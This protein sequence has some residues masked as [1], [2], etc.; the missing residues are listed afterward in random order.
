MELSQTATYRGSLR[1]AFS[2]LLTMVFMEARGEKPLL[3]G[4]CALSGYY[5]GH[6]HPNDID[7]FWKSTAGMESLESRIGRTYQI[8]PDVNEQRGLRRILVQTET[9]D[10]AIHSAILKQRWADPR[11]WQC[12]SVTC[13]DVSLQT[14]DYLGL[15]KLVALGNIRD[16]VEERSLSLYDLLMMLRGGLGIED[17]LETVQALRPRILLKSIISNLPGGAIVEGRRIN[18]EESLAGFRDRLVTEWEARRLTQLIGPVE[19]W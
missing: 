17:L 5:L 19:D 9:E 3:G 4:S 10:V 15:E 13:G 14:L 1:P 11:V 8:V 18:F 12:F 6:R 16:S 7:L 2:K